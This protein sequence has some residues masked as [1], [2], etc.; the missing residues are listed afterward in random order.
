VKQPERRAPAIRD[1]ITAN[2]ATVREVEPA[3]RQIENGAEPP[4]ELVIGGLPVGLAPVPLARPPGYWRWPLSS[5]EPLNGSV[6]RIDD[7]MMVVAVMWARWRGDGAGYRSYAPANRRTDT[8]T[9]SAA[10]DCADRSPGAGADQAAADC[11]VGRIVWV[12][13]SG[14]REQ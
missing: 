5:T 14:G 10:R 6:G 11:A 4:I 12:S 7:V 9:M 2:L 1:W 8:G 3:D 13:E